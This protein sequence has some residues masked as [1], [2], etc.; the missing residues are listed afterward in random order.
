MSFLDLILLVVL[1]SALSAGVRIGFVARVAGWIGAVGGLVVGLR[2]LPVVLRELQATGS[3]TRLILTVVILLLAAA[4]GGAV[5]EAVG[6]RLRSAVPRQVVGLDR[7]AGAVAGLVSVLVGLW[8]FLPIASQVPLVAGPVRS[9]EIL[10]ALEELTP[11]APDAARRVRSLV[12]EARFPEV[13]ADLRPAP[14][15]GRPPTDVPVPDGVVDRAV[16]S[17]V[18]VESFGCGGRHEG[19]GFA[20][21][22]DL[23]ATN[24]HVVAGADRLRVRRPDG[25]VLSASIVTFDPNRDLA[26]LS[27]PGLGQDPLPLANAPV[28][29]SAAVLGYPGGQNSV[30]V[31]PAT[32]Q[33]EQPT[34]GR[35]IYGRSRTQ[36]QVLFLASRLR[37]GDSGA[38]L[39]DARGGVIGAAFAVAPDRSG[40]AYALDDSEL[41]AVLAMPRRRGAGGP[42]I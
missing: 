24:A 9:S 16:A 15:M 25:Q 36:R 23:V 28:G 13:F 35:D 19:S 5:G 3:A 33:D 18:N 34:V 7:A 2:L 21:A 8:L 1:L 12:A 14:D 41:R 32:V 4:V 30:R 37:R 29:T 6:G 27:V 39:I 10:R 31:A 17:S 26:L 11:Q 38:A 20:V 40:T 42:C 22:P